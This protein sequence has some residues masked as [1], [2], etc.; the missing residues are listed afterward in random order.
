MTGSDH[1]TPI[2]PQG[3]SL[4][5]L[6]AKIAHLESTAHCGTGAGPG[7]APLT[8]GLDAIDRYLPGGGLQRGAVHE[9]AAGDGGAAATGFALVLAARLMAR[10]PGRSLL[11]CTG[12]RH[13]VP[14]YGPGL[15]A[16]GVAPAELL[17]AATGGEDETLWAME[18]GLACPALAGVVGELHTL[19]PTAGRRL[20]LAARESG[21]TALLLRP[22]GASGATIFTTRWQVASTPLPAPP[23]GSGE[24]CAWQVRLRR[25]RGAMPKSW[26]LLWRPSPFDRNRTDDQ[27]PRPGGAPAGA[28]S[29]APPPGGGTP[30][31]GQ[32][33][34]PHRQSA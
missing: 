29:L 21:V 30:A 17:L 22:E 25:A 26:H 27:D 4:A 13:A 32:A 5:R 28:L 3:Q 15:G 10:A 24:A 33:P 31:R 18:E 9:I 6:R 2:R 23:H 20:A 1:G 7:A 19:S 16:F 8:L 12:G 14:L 11:W 34:E